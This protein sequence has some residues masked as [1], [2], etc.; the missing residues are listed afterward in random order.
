MKR[1][2][3]ISL[4]ILITVCSSYSQIET[5]YYDGE[6]MRASNSNL[7]FETTS[8]SKTTQFLSAEEVTKMIKYHET[9]DDKYTNRFG[10]PITV[11]YS[12]DDGVWTDTYDGR[13]WSMTIASEN[14]TSLTFVFRNLSL[15]ENA[16]LYIINEDESVLYGP[17]TC[18]LMNE[19]AFLLTDIITGSEATIYLY[20]PIE[21]QGNSSLEITRV[22]HGYTPSD[23]YNTNKFTRFNSTA[24]PVCYTGWYEMANSVGLIISSSGTIGTGT[25]IMTTDYSFKPYFITN[26]WHIDSDK[27]GVISSSESNAIAQLSFRFCSQKTTCNGSTLATTYTFTGAQLRSYWSD[28]RFA[29][30]ELTQNVQLQSNIMWAGWDRSGN[31]PSAGVWIGN[32]NNGNELKIA[33]K[34]STISSATHSLLPTAHWLMEDSSDE[35]RILLSYGSPLFDQSKRLVGCQN[36]VVS[37]YSD[38][39]NDFYFGKFCLSWPGGGSNTN[40]LSNWLD[41]YNT[42]ATVMDSYKPMSI[43]GSTLIYNSNVYYV[44]NLASGMAV[45]WTLSDS[46]YSQNCMQVNTPETNQCTI[47]RNSSQMMN[48]ATLTAT[49]TKNGIT[50]KTLQ[51]TISTY[52]SFEGT[53]YNGQTTKQINLPSPLYVLPGTLVDINSLNLIG[54]TVSQNGGNGTPTSWTFSNSSGN[55]KVGMPSSTGIA[56]VVNV[57]CSNNATFNLPII[58]TNNSG[59][60]SLSNSDNSMELFVTSQGIEG[61]IQTYNDYQEDI[62]NVE[63]YNAMTTEKVYS[64][65]IKGKSF[66]IDTTGWHSGIYIVCTTNNKEVLSQ[67]IV[68]K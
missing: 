16:K 51:I 5:N 55:L 37:N 22:I 24:D 43:S 29:L 15:S 19:D 31:N 20:E 49:I 1:S 38:W 58:T 63:I 48:G 45:S 13:V 28:T 9:T 39:H 10:V 68:I 36:Y 23:V 62:W 65:N 64:S 52:E 33:F 40:R 6:Q 56:I 47:T 32:G 54:A 7:E 12:L 42:G 53:Y 59:L 57:I 50:I 11:S 30:L 61:K 4:L 2:L 35:G 14:A 18:N 25:L 46:Y 3:L 67:K 41:P 66:I 17:V 27:D 34:N 44:N 60:L 26:L 21:E 8:I